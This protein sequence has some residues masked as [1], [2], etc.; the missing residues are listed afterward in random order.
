MCRDEDDRNLAAFSVQLRLQ[1]ETGHSRHADIRDQACS[2]VLLPEFRI[3][4]P[5][6]TLVPASQPPS[7]G[8]AARCALNHHHRQLYN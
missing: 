7:A 2:L 3:P 6:Q 4:P 5:T 1:F 8:P